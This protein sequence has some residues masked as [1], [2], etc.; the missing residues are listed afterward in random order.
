MIGDVESENF[1]FS[2]SVRDEKEEKILS[3]ADSRG[4]PR[5]G[6][7]ESVSVRMAVAWAIGMPSDS[8]G[9]ELSNDTPHGVVRRGMCGSMAFGSRPHMPQ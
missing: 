9:D 7:T 2:S 3:M 5:P 8:P 4:L 6:C 1:F